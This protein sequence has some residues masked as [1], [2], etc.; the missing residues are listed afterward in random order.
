MPQFDPN[1]NIK[2]QPLS[3]NDVNAGIEQKNYQQNHSY[4]N[5]TPRLSQYNSSNLPK[6]SIFS[7][8][9]ILILILSFYSIFSFCW[10][11]ILYLGVDGSQVCIDDNAVCR[12]SVPLTKQAVVAVNN[13]IETKNQ[14][15][16]Q[17]SAKNFIRDIWQNQTVLNDNL[18]T[19]QQ[20]VEKSINSFKEYI[21][22]YIRFINDKPEFLK[23]FSKTELENKKTDIEDQIINLKLMQDNNYQNKVNNQKQINELYL[24][25]GERQDNSYISQR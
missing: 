15:V 6:K 11:A 18:V 1:Y 10:I 19:R 2:S 22:N 12:I 23:G 9:N 24:D 25:L 3:H 16:K 21:Q 13:E 4:N 14:L 7:L 5:Q 8:K 20:L 17:K